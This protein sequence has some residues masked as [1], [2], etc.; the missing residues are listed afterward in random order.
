MEQDLELKVTEYEARI[1]SMEE[2]HQ[3]SISELQRM[4]IQQQQLGAKLVFSVTKFVFEFRL[5]YS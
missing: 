4:L 3:H 2:C 1:E 5:N